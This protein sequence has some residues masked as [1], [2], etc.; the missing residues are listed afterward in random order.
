MGLPTF[1]YWN[2]FR[3]AYLGVVRIVSSPIVYFTVFAAS[4]SS[5]GYLLKEFLLDWEIPQ[6]SVNV[7]FH[8]NSNGIMDIVYYI[9]SVDTLLNILNFLIS[10]LNN[11]INFVPGFIAGLFVA[12]RIYLIQKH[13]HKT[14]IQSKP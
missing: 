11:I 13:A 3:I 6:V 1:D 12:R 2:I 4:L 10:S 7:F 14:I 5:I 9:L 8:N